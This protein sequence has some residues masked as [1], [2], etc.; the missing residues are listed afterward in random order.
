MQN[1]NKL[2]MLHMATKQIITD[3]EL[4]TR[5]ENVHGES[6]KEKQHKAGKLTA[7]ERINLLIDDG[8]FVET[9][10]YLEHRCTYFSMDPPKT[11][12]S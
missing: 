11:V 6:R 5:L 4:K 10:V 2:E 9:N 8:T 12:K 3:Q 7:W 1:R